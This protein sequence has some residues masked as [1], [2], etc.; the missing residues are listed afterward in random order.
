[1]EP[2]ARPDPIPRAMTGRRVLAAQATTWL[3]SSVEFGQHHQL[4]LALGEGA[5]IAVDRQI[6]GRVQH[7]LL[8]TI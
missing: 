2:A 8:A 7:V 5:V 6:F 1:M 3:T 4:R